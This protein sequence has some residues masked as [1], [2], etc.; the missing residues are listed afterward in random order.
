MICNYGKICKPWDLLWMILGVLGLVLDCKSF[1]GVLGMCL[2]QEKCLNCTGRLKTVFGF[3]SK[4][5]NL[6]MPFQRFLGRAFCWR[7]LHICV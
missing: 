2:D 5:L 4:I 7:G 3:S 6:V 1:L